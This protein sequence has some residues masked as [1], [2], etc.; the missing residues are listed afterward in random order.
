MLNH[1]ICTVRTFLILAVLLCAFPSI[2]QNVAAVDG[3]LL[4]KK[5]GKPIE[6]VSVFL[7]LADSDEHVTGS[8][9]DAEG[10][11]KLD[12]LPFGEFYL[13][14]QY[15]SFQPI[16][17]ETFILNAE[18]KEHHLGKLQMDGGTEIL[19]TVEI[20]A[21][22]SQVE[23]SLDKRVYNVGQDLNSQ[24]GSA[25]EILNNVP[26][27]VVDIEGGVSLR[28]SNNVRILVD[29]K[30]S[31]LIGT[32]S[33][34]GLRQIPASM[35][36]KVEVI[37]NP[38]AR[39]DAEGDAGIINIV[40][41]KEKK[42][43]FNGSFEISGGLPKRGGLAANVNYRR[44][45][46]NLFANY[47]TNYRENPGY[48]TND[49]EFTLADTTYYTVIKRN[50]NRTGVSHSIKTGSDFFWGK[51]NII[52]GAFLYKIS[53]EFNPSTLTYEDLNSEKELQLL[54]TRI[55]EEV[56]I[57]NDIEWSLNYEKKL[58]GDKHKITANVRYVL[59]EETEDSDIEQRLGSQTTP[60]F[61]R[62]LNQ[63]YERNIIGNLDYIRPLKNA[64]KLETGWRSTLRNINNPYLVED[65]IDEQW[66]R[67]DN[68]SNSLFYTE[69]VHAAYAIYGHE[70]KRMSYQLGLRSEYTQIETF[71]EET[72]ERYPRDF[73]N[74][75]PSAHFT[76]KLSKVNS[77]QVS[78]SRRINRPSFW[79]L[80]P[81]YSFTDPR[82]FHAGN[83]NLNPEY[84]NSWEAGHIYFSKS[85]SLLSTLYYR[86]SKGV[87]QRVLLANDD[88]TTLSLPINLS[89]YDA[90]GF[91]FTFSKKMKKGFKFSGNAN[92][93]QE[94][95][96][97]EYEGVSYQSNALTASGRLNAQFTLFKKVKGQLSG[98][99]RGPFQTTQGYRR[100][101]WHT[102]L[103]FSDDFL[104]GRATWN[105][106]LRDVF[107]TRKRRRFTDTETLYSYSEFQWRS[108]YL[109]ATVTY[110][111]NQKKSQKAVLGGGDR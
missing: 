67:L 15:L 56:E 27:V 82:N 29:G 23:L 11:F 36:E 5:S 38:S 83:P 42:Q 20:E 52:T 60:T 90:V 55:D 111:I 98:N 43:G 26:S 72:Q 102:D 41:K 107:N 87:M 106:S 96:N 45:H 22:K 101:Q 62:V 48:G 34:G 50:H 64:S 58:D 61:Q 39:Y 14:C 79:S 73:F 8:L 76:Y 92:F 10:R 47:G 46:F 4:E 85:G 77:V 68:F 100:S 24:G 91:E 103:G 89:E 57:E 12:N 78:Y 59:S 30:P 94:W 86:S 28:G 44:K 13:K 9:T 18:H 1:H 53:D 71:L 33:G 97:G 40:L 21:E 19:E 3:Q 88:G 93:F 49:M 17:T 37:T 95:V 84:I 70:G 80:N 110:R 104:K 63:E 7:F 16:K 65:L 69:N 109:M 2:S 35:I 31:G 74:L 99:Y 6:F 54:T 25:E 66:V 81:F 75:F 105:V 32:G 51:N 108:R